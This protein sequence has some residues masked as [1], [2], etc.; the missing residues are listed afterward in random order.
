M[1]RNKTIF[2]GLA[3]GV[4]AGCDSGGLDSFVPEVVLSSV[5]IADQIL[6]T[7]HLSTT[8][9]IG[10]PFDS[11]EHDINDADV[12]LTWVQEDSTTVELPYQLSSRGEGMY[13][14]ANLTEDVFVDG[15]STYRV[16]AVV[17]GFAEPVT[18]ETIVP[19]AFSIVVPPPD[20]IYYQVGESPRMD[21]TPSSYPGRQ[22]VYVFNVRARDIQNFPLTPFAADLVADRGIN[23]IDLREASSP[24]LNESNYDVNADGTVRISIVW[25]AFNFYGPQRLLITALDDALI[26]FVES[27]TIQFLPTTLSPGEIP[28][29]VS[30]VQ[31]GI[32][33]FGSA[34]QVTA[35]TFLAP[36]P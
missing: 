24:L 1:L 10:E 17:P 33:V 14:Y 23:P 16:E 8:G 2:L 13:V 27:Q 26:D 25:L 22:N 18:A 6:P 36:A 19:T 15:G 21:I 29:V 34:A 32:G 28:N 12:R 11:A 20:T 9:P 35:L 5:L 30:N 4:L 31:N 7:I 3:L